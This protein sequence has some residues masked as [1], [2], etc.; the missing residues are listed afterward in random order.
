MPNFRQ[1]QWLLIAI[2]I[3]VIIL[4]TIIAAPNSSGKNNSGSTYSRHPDGYGAWYEYMSQTDVSIERWRKPF[5]ESLQE[6]QGVTY[7]QIRS[8]GDFLLSQSHNLPPRV[9]EWI[10]QGNTLIIVGD[11]QPATAANFSSFL[12]YREPLSAK[13]IKIETTRRYRQRVDRQTETILGDRFGAVVWQKEIGRGKV[14]YCTTPYLA[15]NAYQDNPD[16]YEF[17]A[18]LASENKAIWVDEYI[19]G[20]KDREIIAREQRGLF[21][22]LAK[23]PW[24]LLF[25]QLIIGTVVASTVAFRRFGQP[26]TPHEAIADNSTAYID[27]LAGVLEKANSS[28]FVVE[29]VGKD[30]RRKL[31]KSL[32]LGSA[33]VSRE[34]LLAAYQQKGSVSELNQL[35]NLGDRGRKPNDTQLIIWSDRWQNINRHE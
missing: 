7:I 5:F 33:L 35:L 12:P 4:L 31:Q 23:T 34:T 27:A 19:H 2:A 26:L 9:R 11:Y 15:A 20:Y 6:L 30:E 24:F 10:S 3:A 21:S 28:D 29:T 1:R 22:Y 25:V 8:K 14:I 13:R 16:N 17:L 18:Q 32:G